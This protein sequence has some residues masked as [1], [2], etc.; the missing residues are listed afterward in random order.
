MSTIDRQRIEAVRTLERSGYSFD[1]IEWVAPAG[2][3]RTPPQSTDAAEAMHSLLAIRA[4]K[5][6]G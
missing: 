4:D 1:G 5:N 3:V 6:A 2:S